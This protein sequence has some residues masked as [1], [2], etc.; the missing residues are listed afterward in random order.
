MVIWVDRP[1]LYAA[2]AVI[3]VLA[4]AGMALYQWLFP[5]LVDKLR[6]DPRYQAAVSLYMSLLQFE[7]PTRDDRLSALAVACDQLE[8][9]HDI[10]AGEARRNLLLLVAPYDRGRSYDLRHEA[11]AY[12]Q[13]GANELALSHFE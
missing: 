8:K 10:P 7:G 9:Q 2:V 6:T 13:I 1:E 3:L 5:P 4:V 11:I 12:E